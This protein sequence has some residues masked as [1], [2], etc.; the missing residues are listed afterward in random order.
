[1]GEGGRTM[2]GRRWTMGPRGFRRLRGN[3]LSPTSAR[4]RH[5]SS[6]RLSSPRLRGDMLSPTSAR[7]R[8]ASPPRLSSPRLRGDMLS[9]ASARTG[10][11]HPY[12]GT[13][14]RTGSPHAPMR[15]APRGRGFPPSGLSP[16]QRFRAQRDRGQRNGDTTNRTPR[17]LLR[18]PGPSQKRYA[19]RTNLALSSKAPPR[20]TRG[21]STSE[22]SRPSAGSY[23]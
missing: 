22:S 17:N 20:N 8:H 15:C 23:G 5:A 4:S 21:P 9:P 11:P 3:S 16:P 14:S 2:D 18:S 19:Q 12:P 13:R 1:M 7:S 6:P 10:M